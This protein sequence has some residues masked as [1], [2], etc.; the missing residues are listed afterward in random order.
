MR[1]AFRVPCSAL[2]DFVFT[3]E[4]SGPLRG[5]TIDPGLVKSTPKAYGL[6]EGS[7]ISTEGAVPSSRRR[8]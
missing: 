6:V 1:S 5:L 7:D 2:R 3:L 8:G 4:L